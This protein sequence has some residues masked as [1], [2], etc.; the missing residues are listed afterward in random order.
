[1]LIILMTSINERR[2][3]MAILRAMGT[4]PAQVFALIPGEAMVITLAG[5]GPGVAL[6]AAAVVLASDW[7]ARA[8]GLSIELNLWTPE[9]VYVVITVTLFGGPIGPIPGIR[10]YRYSLADGMTVR[11]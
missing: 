4:R 3:E 9:L 6:V 1:M 5:I 7:L 10:T 8:F 2:R 11:V